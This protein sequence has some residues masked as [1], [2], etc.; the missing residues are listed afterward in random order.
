M[1]TQV[2]TATCAST[3]APM[4][5][6]RKHSNQPSK[7]TPAVKKYR[8][9]LVEKNYLSTMVSPDTWQHLNEQFRSIRHDT[10]F[11]NRHHEV[12]LILKHMPPLL[13][14]PTLDRRDESNNRKRSNALHIMGSCMAS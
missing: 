9:T 7:I 14:I 3:V 4:N 11:W 8:S 6:R 12:S 1:H 5:M 13:I 2:A 10:N